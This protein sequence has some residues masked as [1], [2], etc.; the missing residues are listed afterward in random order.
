MN[1]QGK[2]DIQWDEYLRALKKQDPAPNRVQPVPLLVLQHLTA[3]VSPTTSPHEVAVVDLATVAF[4][5]LNRP[6]E[7][8]Q[9]RAQSDA[10]PFRLC[11][12]E[13]SLGQTTHKGHLAPLG[14][15]TA[16]SFSCLEYTT[17]KNSRKGE[18]IGH[19]TSGHPSLCP[20]RAL[21]RRVTA[22]RAQN[23]PPTTPLHAVPDSLEAHVT[24]E[25]ITAALR[26]S[27]EATRHI[28]GIDP[29]KIS[30][31]SLRSGGAMALLCAR[32]DSNLIKLVGRWQSDEMLKYLHVQAVPL[33]HDL[34]NQMVT[35]GS[36]HF[37]PGAVI[38]REAAT[39]LPEDVVSPDILPPDSA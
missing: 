17:Q 8:S 27:A 4:F 11:D 23:A 15:V 9:P 10:E 26:R 33:L 20:V 21:G 16:A 13:F 1:D 5:Y 35:H 19:K 18:R 14:F 31:R 30:A 3:T 22:L 38:P 37:L 28:T 25:H 32:V 34:S 7:Y 2:T 12:T 6:G 24:S 39:F 29:S 36:F